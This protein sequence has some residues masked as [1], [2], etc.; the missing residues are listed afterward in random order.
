MSMIDSYQFG[1]IVVNGESYSSDV[2][3]FSDR[4]EC[5]WRRKSSHKL[6]LAD[7]AA[8]LAENPD[9]VVIGTGMAGLMEVLPEVKQAAEAR[10]I[11]LI[12]EPT[13]K[14]CHAYNQ[15]YQSQKAVA[16]L[17]LTC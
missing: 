2:I 5:N 13:E 3:I 16:A 10:G 9:V 6:Y 14:A 4:V 1:R 17:H 11:Q 7:M 8:V 12:V 15:L